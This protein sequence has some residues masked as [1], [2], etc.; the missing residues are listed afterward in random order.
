MEACSGILRE[1]GAK[2][3]FHLGPGNHLQHI[4]ERLGAGLDALDVF[5]SA[6]PRR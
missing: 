3:D 5:L 4:P 2:V 6:L 1:H